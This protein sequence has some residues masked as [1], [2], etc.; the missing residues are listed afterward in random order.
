MEL[1]QKYGLL[2]LICLIVLIFAVFMLFRMRRLRRRTASLKEAAPDPAIVERAAETLSKLIGF[3]TLSMS[4]DDGEFVRQNL[5]IRERFP[6]LC[7]RLSVSAVDGRGLLCRWTG[8]DESLRPVL[9]CAHTDV[10]PAGSG[11]S[12]EPFAGT[13]E[14]GFI[15][16]RGAVDCKGPA[17]ALLEAVE[18]LLGSGFSPRRDVYI[19]LGYD[20][21]TGAKL[22]AGRMAKYFRENGIEFEKPNWL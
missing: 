11:W 14:D 9:F 7:S 10:V 6:L 17:V 22:G 4:E 21:E 20:E 13:R 15:Y 16:G 5:Y 19:E 3:K 18:N 12:H 8:A 2:M 1:L